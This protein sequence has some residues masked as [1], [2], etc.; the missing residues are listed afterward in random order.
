MIGFIHLFLRGAIVEII[1][2]VTSSV[3]VEVVVS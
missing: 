1:M 2:G 3:I